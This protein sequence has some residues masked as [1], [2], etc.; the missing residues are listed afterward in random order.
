MNVGW[1]RTLQTLWDPTREIILQLEEAQNQHE[2]PEQ[3]LK[4]LK[5]NLHR[6]LASPY[7]G[8]RR[9][10]FKGQGFELHNLREYQPGDDIRKI[11]WH[12]LARTGVP[13]VR[14][15]YEEKQVPIW[16]FV[17]TT[18]PMHFG[19]VESKLA[20]AKQ[21]VGL[22][23]VLALEMGNRVGLVLWQGA[24]TPR[25]I[26]PKSTET[27]LQWI[28]QE[29]EAAMME[30]GLSPV[31]FPDITALFQHHSLV[32]LLSDFAFFEPLPVALRILSRLAPKHRIQSVL[33]MDPLEKGL[34]HGLGWLPLSDDRT[35]TLCWVNLSDR[36]MIKA[37]KKLIQ[38]EL[39]ERQRHFSPWSR[40]YHVSTAED[41][42]NVLLNLVKIA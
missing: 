19:Q 13:H 28:L 8:D 41:P 16:F 14:E 3:L 17:D 12:V 7:P 40:L 25:L 31:G 18:A 42:L 27:N 35:K 15:H 4:R 33:L 32:F 2:R 24:V 29:I 6:R 22:L 36:W 30:P 34:S 11:D 9:G 38:Q 23:G 37:Y 20:Y 26:P 10:F 39:S 1:M 5:M 21:L